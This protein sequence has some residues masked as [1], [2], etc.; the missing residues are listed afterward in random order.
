MNI[1]LP[2]VQEGQELS[3]TLCPSASPQGWDN[4]II[5]GVVLGT[6]KQPQVKYLAE[7][8][9]ASLEMLAL[10]NPA[11][12]DEIFRIATPCVGQQCEH[13]DGVRCGLVKRAVQI[14]PVAT[15]LLP[16]CRIRSRCMWW[17]QEGKA[18]CLR[19]P[20]VVTFYRN[21]PEEYQSLARP[22]G[23]SDV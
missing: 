21:L 5:F 15:D 18:A 12:P 23:D 3:Q 11:E 13:F 7:P 9:P 6:P 22:K 14:L 8:Q 10:A 16:P 17:H 4:G 1:K 2:D 19:C 20:E